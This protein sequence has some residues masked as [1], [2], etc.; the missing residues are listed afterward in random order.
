LPIGVLVSMLSF[1]LM[2]SIPNAWNSSN[3]KTRC[4]VLL[5]KR[6]NRATR[7]EPTLPDIGHHAVQFRPAILRAA[8]SF[9]AV[10]VGDLKAA[11]LTWKEFL[12]RHWDQIVASD[13]FTVEVWTPSGL[14]RFVILFFMA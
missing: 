7:I 8:D 13:F 2:K 12:S 1:R 6:S 11:P 3:A 14:Q 5:A 9:V 10:L 4:F